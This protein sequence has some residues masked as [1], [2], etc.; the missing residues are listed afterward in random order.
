MARHPK[1]YYPMAKSVSASSNYASYQKSLPPFGPQMACDV[2]GVHD[3]DD[4][5][6]VMDTDD[7]YG[8]EVAVEGE[9]WYQTELPLEN[10]REMEQ[11]HLAEIK[12]FER[13]YR[14]MCHHAMKWHHLMEDLE[15]NQ[16]LKK[17][18]NDIQLMRKLG[19]SSGV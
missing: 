9:Y 15:D 6:E 4:C 17:M 14:K 3:W 13:A 16:Q 19:G 1:R 12:K 8:D 2:F 7:Y 10:V 5:E 18:F 11:R